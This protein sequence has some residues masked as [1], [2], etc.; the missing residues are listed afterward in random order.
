MHNNPESCVERVQA[1][2]N[3][4][5]RKA[6][7]GPI[8]LRFLRV[9][10]D[11]QA[12]LHG[13][14]VDFEVHLGCAAVGVQREVEEVTDT[15]QRQAVLV[16]VCVAGCG[17]R[18]W[19][20]A[21]ARGDDEPAVAQRNDFIPVSD[22]EIRHGLQLELRRGEVL[23]GW[24]AEGDQ[25][26]FFE[27]LPQEGEAADSKTHAGDAGFLIRVVGAGRRRHCELS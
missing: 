10:D 21:V 19:L 5:K 11:F 12:A 2:Q 13:F 9:R 22:Q 4:E 24:W 15:L 23:V 8:S 25:A 14:D 26:G 6:V 7:H 27:L 20:L 18:R 16:I 3:N 17:G 1:A